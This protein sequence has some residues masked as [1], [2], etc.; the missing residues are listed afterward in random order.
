VKRAL[1]GRRAVLAGTA[2][3]LAGAYAR[4]SAADDD[5][6]GL[7]SPD[8][9]VPDD[10]ALPEL[11]F[12]NLGGQ[13]VTLDRFRGK[14]VVLNFWATWCGPC[15][16]ELPELDKLAVGGAVT[17]LAVSADRGGADR[18]KAFLA[19]HKLNHLTVLLDP[20]STAVHAVGVFGFPTTLILDAQGRLR[21]RLE[22]PAAWSGAAPDVKKLT[23]ARS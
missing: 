5:D 18:V 13:T 8:A 23:A 9:I 19:A 10:A 4:K 6:S 1:I 20:D 11:S 12:T 14:P 15:V 21:G 17:V 22:G 3:L 7:K 16:A 2:T